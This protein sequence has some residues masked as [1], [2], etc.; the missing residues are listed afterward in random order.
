MFGCG[1][2]E[3]ISVAAADRAPEHTSLIT[4]LMTIR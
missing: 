4:W 1:Y 2:R 3:V